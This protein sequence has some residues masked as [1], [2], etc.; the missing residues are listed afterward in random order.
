MATND[1]AR[2]R[3][4]AARSITKKDAEFRSQFERKLAELIQ[5]TY[6][7]CAYE[8]ESL[9]YLVSKR[10]TPDFLLPNGIYIEAKGYWLPE[11]RTR[12]LLVRQQHT[13]KDIRFV[14]QNAHTRLSKRSKTTYADWCDKHRFRWAHRTIPNSWL[15]EQPK[16]TDV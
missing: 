1:W 12:H 13:D 6:G 5:Q 11:D 14:F 2:R 3:A 4:A 9:T 15:I 7:E 10:Y 8:T 16:P